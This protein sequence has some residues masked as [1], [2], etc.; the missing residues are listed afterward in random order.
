MSD[1]IDVRTAA[2]LDALRALFSE[3]QRAIQVDLFVE[4][5]DPVEPCGD[6]RTHATRS[7]AAIEAN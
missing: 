1:L 2:E 4:P 3:Y 6:V 5:G 7:G